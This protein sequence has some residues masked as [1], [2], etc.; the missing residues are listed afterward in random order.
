MVCLVISQLLWLQIG[1]LVPQMYQ[2]AQQ[3]V[4]RGVHCAMIRR[5]N[6]RP[7]DGRS[8]K[9]TTELTTRLLPATP[10]P[11]PRLIADLTALINAAYEVAEKGLWVPG[12][13]RTDEGEVAGYVR[14]GELA[15]AES[16]DGVI[17]GAIRLH[18]LDARTC[19]FGMLA[20]SPDH[21]GTGVG[22]ALVRFAERHARHLGCVVMQLELLVP[23]EWVHPSK[24][25]LD[26]WYTRIGYR[27][28]RT[29]AIEEFYPSLAPLLATECDFVIYHKTLTGPGDTD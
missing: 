11:S 13:P 22:R 1:G 23:R 18:Q 10:R 21:Q 8:T 15:V 29:G 26:R 14:A 28:V 6:S 7:H 5:V 19:E 24:E 27:P 3:P 2:G 4:G 17:V 12:T 25:F 9:S 20:A 16:P